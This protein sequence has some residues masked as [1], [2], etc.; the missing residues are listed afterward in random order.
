MTSA[1]SR[2]A[3]PA[4]GSLAIS[5]TGN[6]PLTL[7]G[8]SLPGS[9]FGY[10]SPPGAI[11]P[12]GSANLTLSFTPTAPGARAATLTISSNDPDEGPTDVALTGFGTTA[13]SAGRQTLQGTA[14]LAERFVYTALGQANGII[15]TF[16]PG[17]DVLDVSALLAAIP[18]TGT[19]PFADGTLVLTERRGSTYVSL[20]PDGRAGPK[21]AVTLT[22]LQGVP[23]AGLVR[24]RDIAWGPP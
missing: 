7:T 8:F 11:A 9:D 17:Q 22:Q 15:K 1:M 10:S 19:D 23:V 6:L 21:V 18:Y 2:W 4:A 24:A 5:N 13:P 20:D 12:G 16:T 3:G 14:G